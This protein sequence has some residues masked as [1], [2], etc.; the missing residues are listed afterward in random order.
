M[1]SYCNDKDDYFPVHGWGLYG[2]NAQGKED[3][4]WMSTL[5]YGGY[6]PAPL[7]FRCPSVPEN[8]YGDWSNLPTWFPN[9]SYQQVI[10]YGFNVASL[11]GKVVDGKHR[12][13][14]VGMLR[15][16]AG[17]I[18][19]ADTTNSYQQYKNNRDWGYYFLY[20]YYPSDGQTTSRG[21]VALRHAGTCNVAW[22]DGHV[23]GE[24]VS[25]YKQTLGYSQADNPY[26]YAGVFKGIGGDNCHWGY[27]LQ[28]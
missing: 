9:G 1:M 21:I 28:Q 26:K 8:P 24:Q 2:N 23:T 13:I 10:D 11:G 17:T 19:L 20:G 15:S 6:V 5:W 3:K 4:T 25:G 14:K 12:G 27:Y 16:P 18:M 22:A 7:V